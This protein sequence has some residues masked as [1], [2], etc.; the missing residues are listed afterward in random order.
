MDG[1]FRLPWLYTAA[2]GLLTAAGK[3]GDALGPVLVSDAPLL[4]LVLN[5]NDLHLGLTTPNTHWL[6]WYIIGT[7]RRLAE[8]PVFFLI[9]W[10]YSDPRC[11]ALSREFKALCEEDLDSSLGGSSSGFS[12][13]TGPSLAESRLSSPF[14]KQG[15]PSGRSKS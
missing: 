4:L 8:D 15:Q 2:L 11:H 9:G 10:H 5:A 7:L 3:L 12:R 14:G 13:A 6:P 1:G